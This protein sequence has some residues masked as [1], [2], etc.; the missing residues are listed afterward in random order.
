MTKKINILGVEY[1]V[2][3]LSLKQKLD[4]YK[5]FW[6]KEDA[7]EKTDVYGFTDLLNKVIVVSTYKEY[8]FH[9]NIGET[10]WH[11]FGHVFNHEMPTSIMDSEKEAVMGE[12]Y[13]RYRKQ[14][15]KI[16]REFEKKEKRA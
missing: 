10:L 8:K 9:Y 6:P 11:E 2:K 15:D 3:M 7:K 12:Y 5:K 16:E 14:L 1:S 13:Y 4:Y